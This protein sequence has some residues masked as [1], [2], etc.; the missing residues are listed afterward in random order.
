MNVLAHDAMT[1]EGDTRVRTGG[2]GVQ[3]WR[4]IYVNGSCVY[5]IKKKKKKPYN[6]TIHHLRPSRIIITRYYI[7]IIISLLFMCSICNCC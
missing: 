7:T 6:I 4:T 2:K 5:V 1:R 3:K